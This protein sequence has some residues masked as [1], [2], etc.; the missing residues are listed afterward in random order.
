MTYGEYL[1]AVIAR[2]KNTSERTGQAAFN[3]LYEVRPEL[4]DEVRGTSLDPF[5]DNG[6]LSG[7]L[8]WVESEW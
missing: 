3:S 8:A 1:D 4:A 7:F 6:K 2:D 5:Y